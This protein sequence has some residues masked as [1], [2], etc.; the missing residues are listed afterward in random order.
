M[1]KVIFAS[2]VFF[3]AL[4]APYS[5]A[6]A[7][8]I[9]Q[10]D[11]QKIEITKLYKYPRGYSCEGM[12]GRSKAVTPTYFRAV[13]TLCIDVKLTNVSELKILSTK[14]YDVNCSDSEISPVCWNTFKGKVRDKGNNN[15]KPY[16]KLS[17]VDND[18]TDL[19][20]GESVTF[21]ITNNRPVTSDYYFEFQ[22]F[23]L[24]VSGSRNSSQW[25]SEYL[26]IEQTRSVKERRKLLSEVN[27][28]GCY[29]KH[30]SHKPYAQFS[31][32][33]GVTF[34]RYTPSLEIE[35]ALSKYPNDFCNNP[36]STGM[37]LFQMNSQAFYNVLWDR[38]DFIEHC[39]GSKSKRFYLIFNFQKQVGDEQVY[40][41]R[42][43]WLDF[44]G[45]IKMKGDYISLNGLIKHSLTGNTEKLVSA[46]GTVS[47]EGNILVRSKSQ[48]TYS[49]SWPHVEY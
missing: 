47:S 16:A 11:H 21:T 23:G 34:N 33:S 46:V 43:T 48:C 37:P 20:P 3:I 38:W 30:L 18:V 39:N 25:Q 40:S 44:S 17:S 7:N 31:K 41:V 49:G 14:L 15:L 1:K 9:S 24:G 28:L 5:T 35:E 32:K 42:S 12:Q 26:K 4:L 36:N 8:S 29:K 27:R 2:C 22:I 45:T 6:S 10:N 19:Y 13:E